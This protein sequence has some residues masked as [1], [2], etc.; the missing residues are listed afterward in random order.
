MI[1][2]SVK[3]G[4]MVRVVIGLEKEGVVVVKECIF[5]VFN[6]VDDEVFDFDCV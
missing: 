4:I 5:D 2:E 3:V 1:F 6:E